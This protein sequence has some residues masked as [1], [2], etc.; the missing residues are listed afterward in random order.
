MLG[1]NKDMVKSNR[2]RLGGREYMNRVGG[3]G[4]HRLVKLCLIEK[5]TWKKDLKAMRVLVHHMD[6]WTK[7]TLHRGD[8]QHQVSRAEVYLVRSRNSKE[9]V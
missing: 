6:T 1:S 4:F 3:C 5:V 2:A 9:A 8:S 7:N